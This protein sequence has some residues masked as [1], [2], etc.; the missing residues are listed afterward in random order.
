MV[1][2][3]KTSLVISL[4]PEERDELETW[5]RSTRT[6]AGLV[7]R[8]RIILLLAAGNSISQISR[9]VGIRRRQVAKWAKR[10][11][12]HGIDG[13]ADK[14]GRGRKPFFPSES[15]GASG[16]VGVRTA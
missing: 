5:Q 11:L 12:K 15:R 9:M 8:G 14:P 4:T 2:G 6:R 7:R 1:R 13:L 10:F 16:E 3:R